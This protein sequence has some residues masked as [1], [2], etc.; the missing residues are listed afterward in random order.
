[1][2]HTKALADSAYTATPI[3]LMVGWTPLVPKQWKSLY[4]LFEPPTL[5]SDAALPTLL[6][7][8]HNVLPL[9]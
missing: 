5:I 8:N 6:R 9:K 4:A 1:M 2:I 7:A 3:I